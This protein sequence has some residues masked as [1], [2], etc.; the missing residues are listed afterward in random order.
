MTTDT[1]EQ[2]DQRPLPCIVCG[3]EPRPVFTDEPSMQPYAATQFSTGGH[4]G[5]T[6]FDPMSRYMQLCI[7]VCDNCL[8]ERKDCV[9]L[10]I[11][12]PR[13][14]KFEWKDWDPED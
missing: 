2:D 6:V 10:V 1:E 4:Y 13:S 7:N 3:F 9:R 14:S 11:E 8:R 5:S 12:T